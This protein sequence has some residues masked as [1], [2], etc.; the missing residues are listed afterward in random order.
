VA[1]MSRGQEAMLIGGRLVGL[2]LFVASV[3]GSVALRHGATH[4]FL[5]SRCIYLGLAA[6]VVLMAVASRADLLRRQARVPAGVTVLFW[7]EMAFAVVVAVLAVT[8]S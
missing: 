6:G 7:V 4:P 3:A 5:T 1:E 8:M 2:A